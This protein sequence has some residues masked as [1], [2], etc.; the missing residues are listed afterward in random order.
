MRRLEQISQQSSSERFQ[1][2]NAEIFIGPSFT[3]GTSHINIEESGLSTLLDKNSFS[4]SPV[5]HKFIQNEG[6]PLV[7]YLGA[8]ILFFT[9]IERKYVQKSETCGRCDVFG[10]PRICICSKDTFYRI[11]GNPPPPEWAGIYVWFD[12]TVVCQADYLVAALSGTEFVGK[13]VDGRSFIREIG[14]ELRHSYQDILFYYEN[15]SLCKHAQ[16]YDLWFFEGLVEAMDTTSVGMSFSTFS[17]RFRPF[18]LKHPNF[19]FM[20]IRSSF[21]NY[22][23]SPVIDNLMYQYSRFFVQYLLPFFDRALLSTLRGHHISAEFSSI[24]IMIEQFSDAYSDGY[25]GTFLEFISEKIGLTVEL[26][27]QIE[28]DF[29]KSILAC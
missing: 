10:V 3:C 22:D 9:R 2:G 27:Q 19:S 14:H 1:L 20:D 23:T 11:R 28:A 7:N 5:M 29:Q 26:L 13:Q 16:K 12:G 6:E 24:Y 17:E 4:L 15:E 21:W 18:L 8:I 25:R